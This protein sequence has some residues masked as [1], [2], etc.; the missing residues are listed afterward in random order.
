MS[1]RMRNICFTLNNYDEKDI[2]GLKQLEDVQYIIFGKE[3]APTTGTPHLQGYIQFSKKVTFNVIRKLFKWNI[4]IADGDARSN[5]K[6]CEKDK[7]VYT[8]GT[9][10][11]QGKR[12]DIK[13]VIQEVKDGHNM[14]HIME[15]CSNFQA[16]RVAEKCLQYFE[17]PRNKD[18]PTWVYWFFGPAGAGKTRIAHAILGE[19]HYAK[20]PGKFWNNYDGEVNVRIDDFRK[21]EY[22]FSNLLRILDRY[23]MIVETKGGAR[24]L[25]AKLIVITSDKAPWEIWSGNDLKQVI[26]RLCTVQRLG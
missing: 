1:E 18:E 3:I 11:S 25:R 19:D 15:D 23:K 4:R 2:Q 5:T 24:Q 22:S 21:D 16:I 14:R 12:N 17:P 6:Y 7:D 10:K 13:R 8:R 20:E 26:R 9:P